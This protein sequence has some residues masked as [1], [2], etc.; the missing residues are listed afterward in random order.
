MDA[1]VQPNG[2]KSCKLIIK[3]GQHSSYDNYLNS[4]KSNIVKNILNIGVN[5][6]CNC[7]IDVPAVNIS[8]TIYY[9]ENSIFLSDEQ[10]ILLDSS[11]TT[12]IVPLLTMITSR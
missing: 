8:N 12:N 10:Q 5:I 1:P 7:N 3:K 9:A 6:D 4:I 2:C 11:T